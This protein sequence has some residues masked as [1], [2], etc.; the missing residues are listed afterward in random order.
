MANNNS[1]EVAKTLFDGDFNCAQSV[2]KALTDVSGLD[3][4][5]S[6][7]LT[8][9]FGG[10]MGMHQEICGAASGACMAIS[11][12]IFH[13]YKDTAEGKD[14]AYNAVQDFMFK[15]KDEMTYVRCIDMTQYDFMIEEEKEKFAQSGRRDEVC[16]PAVSFAAKLA[17][18]IIIDHNS[19]G[20]K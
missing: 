12:A 9:G 14:A 13:M 5:Q 20:N 17:T 8:A 1:S 16:V 11:H 4:L 3:T 15:F 7:A 19:K 6:E 10:G 18:S 2:L